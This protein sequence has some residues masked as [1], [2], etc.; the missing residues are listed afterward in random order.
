M[1]SQASGIPVNSGD[2]AAQGVRQKRKV[3][4]GKYEARLQPR[5]TLFGNGLIQAGDRSV[6]IRGLDHSVCGA[7]LELARGSWSA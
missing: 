2:S 5:R 4:V 6:W 7:R 3:T 1:Y